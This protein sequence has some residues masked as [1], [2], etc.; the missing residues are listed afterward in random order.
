MAK[1]IRPPKRLILQPPLVPVIDVVFNLLIFFM[2]IPNAV[3]GAG[4]LT[5]N[6]PKEGGSLPKGVVDVPPH[7]KVTLESADGHGSGILI[8]IDDTLSL[9]DGFEQL[10]ATLHSMRVRGLAPDYPILLA[11]TMEVKLKYV[12]NAFDAVVAAQ[13]TNIQFQCPTYSGN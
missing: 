6:L 13:F 7:V 5:T 3:A 12:V 4:Y 10:A 11:P 9:G 1:T 2:C 8:A